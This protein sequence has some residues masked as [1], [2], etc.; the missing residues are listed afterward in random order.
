MGLRVAYGRVSTQQQADE[1]ALK[2]QEQALLESSGA[3]E[4]LLDVG[5]GKTTARPQYQRLLELIAQGEVE[6]VLV[7]EQDRLNR[8]VSADLELWSLCDAHGTRITDLNGREIEFRTP[9]GELLS[10]VVSALN[11]HRSKA[12]GAKTKRG[13]E[14]ARKQGL[15]ARPRVPFGLRKIRDEKGR[16]VGIEPDPD[17]APLARQRLEWFLNGKGLTATCT[18][19]GQHHPEETWMQPLQLK[20]WLV[21]PMLTGRLCWHKKG[22]TGGFN[23]VEKDPSFQGLISDTEAEQITTLVEGLSTGRARAGRTTRTFSGLAR[24]CKC[25]LTLSY[26]RSGRSTWYLRCSNPYCDANRR[27]IRVDRV[28]Q[29]LKASIAMHAGRVARLLAEPETLP[30]EV[31][32]LKDEIK[33]LKTIR[34][35]EELINQKLLEIERLTSKK[36]T[37]KE[38]LLIAALTDLSYWDQPEEQLNARLREIVE[39]IE[40]DLKTKVKESKVAA[41]KMRTPSAPWANVWSGDQDNVLAVVPGTITWRINPDGTRS[42]IDVQRISEII[43]QG[44]DLKTSLDHAIALGNKLRNGEGGEDEHWE[45]VETMDWIKSQM[46]PTGPDIE[47]E[48]CLLN[49]PAEPTR[50][51]SAAKGRRRRDSQ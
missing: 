39:F 48:V 5:S 32:E 36:S 25:K 40:V 43:R 23:H 42:A 4:V 33:Q 49:F 15:P 22:N 9:D 27:L 47:T 45:L 14:E 19:I 50:P 38:D 21:N 44:V 10:T 28:L 1:G 29:V 24:C 8:N 18:L 41:V 35:T 46:P 30:L 13:L 37:I 34:G 26:K 3:D 17:T 2:R 12:Y 16:F 51:E 20:R 7:A 31:H 11:Q 6:Q